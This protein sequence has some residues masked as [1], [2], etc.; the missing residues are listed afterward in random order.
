MLDVNDL[1]EGVT[2]VRIL[3][4]PKHVKQDIGDVGIFQKN[5]GDDNLPLKVDFKH[6]YWY[7]DPEHLEIVES[8]DKPVKS[9]NQSED[10]II[11][12]SRWNEIVE[13]LEGGYGM[14]DEEVEIVKSVL[15]NNV[16]YSVINDPVITDQIIEKEEQT[17]LDATHIGD[18]GNCALY[19]KSE[20]LKKWFWWNTSDGFWQECSFSYY[21]TK[22]IP[23]TISKQG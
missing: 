13:S 12:K 16:P 10:L 5:G 9:T 2:K 19:Y 18:T 8:E 4:L 15:K 11:Y 17:H 21:G 14:T 6:D 3:V 20:L 23:I 22:L 7:F 1:V